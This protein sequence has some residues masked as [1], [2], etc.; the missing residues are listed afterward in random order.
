MKTWK[1]ETFVVAVVLVAQM[2]FTEFSTQEII[3]SL[4]V[5][6]TFMHASVADRMQ[7]KMAAQTNP[8]VE[9]HKWLNRYFMSKE[10]LWI[11]YFILTGAFAAITG[12]IVFFL[13]PLWRKYYRKK[14][15]PID[16]S[17]IRLNRAIDLFDDLTPM[18]KIIVMDGYD[19]IT[20]NK[21][22]KTIN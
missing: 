4:A 10:V 3:G 12:A 19:H 17:K 15:K 18:E 11:I 8:E 1:I 9:C 21:M 2:L 22:T 20:G 14:I 7:E 16:Q 6:I 13:Y 5:L